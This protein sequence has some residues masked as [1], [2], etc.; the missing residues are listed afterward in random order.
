MKAQRAT[1][2]LGILGGWYVLAGVVALAQVAGRGGPEFGVLAAILGVLVIAGSITV[3]GM[4]VHRLREIEGLLPETAQR[5]SRLWVAAR[6]SLAAVLPVAT[7]IVVA[8][9][10][11]DAGWILGLA[12]AALG[13]SIWTAA[14][15]TTHVE[16]LGGARV[17][18]AN[19]RFY[20]AR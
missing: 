6:V 8:T 18:R 10:S 20:F 17:W 7:A 5:V 1:V 13:A 9:A 3:I 2:E 19:T 12:C 15:I 16:H 11:H 4:A 14:V